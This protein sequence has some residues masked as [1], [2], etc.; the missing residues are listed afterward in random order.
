VREK[1]FGTGAVLRQCRKLGALKL[2]SGGNHIFLG[3]HNITCWVYSPHSSG[4][5]FSKMYKNFTLFDDV[6]VTIIWADKVL[7]NNI[8]A[9][10]PIMIHF[11]CTLNK[12]SIG[13]HAK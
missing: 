10:L 9:W 3:Q 12:D 7:E 5:Y 4:K 6:W 8:C 11:G 13:M 2:E 1:Q